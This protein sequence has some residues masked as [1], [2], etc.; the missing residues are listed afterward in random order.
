MDL[1]GPY[2]LKGKEKTQIDLMN[3]TMIN[4]ATS[5]FE[6]VELL[7]SQ[8]AELDIPMGTKGGQRCKDTHIQSKQPYFDKMYKRT[9]GNRT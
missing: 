7:M 1:I 5:W 2:T 9:I 6:I 4:P 8:L 3:V